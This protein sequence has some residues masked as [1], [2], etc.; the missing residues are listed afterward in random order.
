M[1]KELL[2]DF[3]LYH[4]KHSQSE[5]HVVVFTLEEGAGLHEALEFV[6]CD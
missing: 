5:E 3:L 6:G 2:A 4:C 1:G